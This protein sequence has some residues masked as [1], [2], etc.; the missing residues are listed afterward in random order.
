MEQQQ[1]YCY[2]QFTVMDQD[3][4]GWDYSVDELL[5]DGTR[6]LSNEEKVEY[7]KAII[8]DIEHYIDSL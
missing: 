4:Y 1:D 8:K 5:D 6:G 3:G 2:L 7:L